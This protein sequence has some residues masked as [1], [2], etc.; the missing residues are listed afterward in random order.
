MFDQVRPIAGSGG[1]IFNTACTDLYALTE[2]RSKSNI[3]DDELSV[4]S[5]QSSYLVS[6]CNLAFVHVS[7]GGH[8]AVSPSA[9]GSNHKVIFMSRICGA[10][11]SH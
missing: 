4:H 2:E 8:V 11:M 7:V 6:L 9:S 3:D 5:V 1:N 10:S